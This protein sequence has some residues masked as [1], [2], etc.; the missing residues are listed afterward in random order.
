MSPS[1]ARQHRATEDSQVRSSLCK[2][3][4]PHS[5]PEEVPSTRQEDRCW[6][7]C[8]HSADRFRKLLACADDRLDKFNLARATGEPEPARGP[9]G[10]DWN[11]HPLKLTTAPSV[12]SRPSLCHQPAGW[13]VGAPVPEGPGQAGG[14]EAQVVL[15]GDPWAPESSSP[16][17]AT[18]LGLVVGQGAFACLGCGPAGGAAGA[19]RGMQNRGGGGQPA[20]LAPAS[21]FPGF[22]TLFGMATQRRLGKALFTAQQIKPQGKGKG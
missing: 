1:L 14:L 16:T 15:R 9:K 3:T 17:S 22:L 13:N 20:L 19:G 12:L 4:L 10:A 7:H 18:K 11:L 8:P 5:P 6:V 2:K 21:F